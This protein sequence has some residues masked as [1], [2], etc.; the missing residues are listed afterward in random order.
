MNYLTRIL[1]TLVAVA[2]AVGAMAQA[3]LP[4]N[5]AAAL[6]DAQAAAAEALAAYET[7][8]PDQPLWR[9]A[10]AAAERAR[11]LAP[12]RPE[13][14]RFLAQAYGLTGW[15]SRALSAWQAYA[16]AGGAMDAP[17]RAAAGAAASKL[18][19]DA[20]KAGNSQNAIALLE[21]AQSY[22]PEDLD[23]QSW[24]GQAYLSVG[25]ASAA[26]PHLQ[27][28][29]Q[30]QPQ[31]EPLLERAQYG[32]N[33]GLANADAYLA[34]RTAFANGDYSAA[35]AGFRTASD[36]APTFLDAQRGVAASLGALGDEQGALEA[37]QRVLTA[38]PG[39]PQA[40]E[41]V[42]RLSALLAPEPEPEPEPEPT[43]VPTPVPTPT[44][45]PEPTP[46]PTPT[47]EPTPT[48]T[49]TPTPAPQP[50]PT[51]TPTPAPTPVPT[52][53]PTPTPTPAPT[54]T[55]PSG[56]IA[57][58][59]GTITARSINDGGQGAFVFVDPAAGSGARVAGAA[60]VDRGTLYLRADVSAKPSS[61][62]M[63]LQLCLVPGDDSV[64]SPP[65][66]DAT[67][68]VV[69]G[70]GAFSASFD[71][72][73]LTGEESVD[74]TRGLSRLLVVLRD[75]ASRPL[76]ERYTRGADGTPIDL[77]PYYPVTL[78]LRLV[79]APAGATFSGW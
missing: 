60:G 66:T 16:A 44:P 74:W 39:D 37:W 29:L 25:N 3:P 59:D 71:M 43:P 9:K 47:P 20:F 14:F 34:A 41:A 42:D 76:D 64:I 28:A 15:T 75:S 65:C 55:T 56:Q 54:P 7:Y 69:T 40:A 31:L 53:T 57:L 19:F 18:G 22:L 49:P 30:A 12:G 24:L 17:A 33:F 73:A 70:T 78:R 10:F 8:Y 32:A 38:A 27:R 2:L 79:L 77:T 4:A 68:L 62:P 58:Y 13:P 50:T 48:P 51:P 46:T 21:A 23:V 35:L 11:D 72:R 63:Q 45:T 6:A 5:A 26:A 36:G 61:T 67:R 1:A 52:P